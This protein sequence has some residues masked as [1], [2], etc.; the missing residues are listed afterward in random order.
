MVNWG[1][2]TVDMG[3]VLGS[4]LPIGIFLAELM[5]VTLSTIRIIF[6]SRG[7]KILA[8]CLG[9]FEIMLWLMA[10][11]QIMKN[12]DCPLCHL[13]FA[14][15][16]TLGNYLGIWFEG[17]LAMGKLGL[18]I[19]SPQVTNPLAEVLS[20]RGYGMTLTEGI[21][22]QGPVQVISMIIKRRDLK[23]VSGL[24]KSVDPQAF[25]AISEVQNTERG[26]FP[27]SQGILSPLFDRLR[28]LGFGS[29]ATSQH[30]VGS[31]AA[32]VTMSS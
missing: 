7:Q 18:K 25:V 2:E 21:G 22:N 1:I 24:I 15:G 28:G 27:V 23:S 4:W 14:G 6:V 16:F 12:L 13:A 17:V 10:I 29:M 8:S 9:F 11:G 26:V 32:P 20:A 31:N 3:L 19:V 5:V 30:S